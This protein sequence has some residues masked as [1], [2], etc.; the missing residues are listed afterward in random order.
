MTS[1]KVGSQVALSWDASCSFGGDDYAVY[2]G[3]LGD[4]ASHAPV[5][6]STGGERTLTFMPGSGSR[7]HLVVPRNAEVE[8]SYG[9]HS[10][11]AE[12]P[13]GS[14]ACAPWEIGGCP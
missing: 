6:C 3:S 13:V 8:G 7:Y 1:A 11:G 2:E 5:T 14:P 12:R 9:T 4:F 10:S